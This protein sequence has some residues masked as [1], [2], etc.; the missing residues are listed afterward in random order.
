MYKTNHTQNMDGIN[1]LKVVLVEKQKTGVWLSEQLG[2]HPSTISLWCSN[3]CQPSL[4][5]LDKIAELLGVDRR[6]LLNK[7][8]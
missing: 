1:R 3:K 4:E 5:R 2:M 8:K 7:S 6:E